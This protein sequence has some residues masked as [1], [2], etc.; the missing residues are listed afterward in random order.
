MSE[1]LTLL[2]VA[3]RRLISL[4]IGLVSSED[5]MGLPAVA[6]ANSSSQLL[7]RISMTMPFASTV[8]VKR[9]VVELFFIVI[10]P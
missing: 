5:R 1:L 4:E 9:R 8:V 10:G 2:V 7:I 6:R 3:L